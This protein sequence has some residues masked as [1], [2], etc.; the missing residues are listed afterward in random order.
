MSDDLTELYKAAKAATKGNWVAVGRWVEN[1]GD[2]LPDICSCD[3]SFDLFDDQNDVL[4]AQYIAAAQPKVVLGL[5][6]EIRLLRKYIEGLKSG[7]F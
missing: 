3:I 5:I 4:N 7:A 1:D 6:E 2:N